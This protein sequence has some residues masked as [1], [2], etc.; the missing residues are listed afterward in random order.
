MAILKKHFLVFDLILLITAA[1]YPLAVFCHDGFSE[2]RKIESFLS[3]T[4]FAESRNLLLKNPASSA[5]IPE[6]ELKKLVASDGAPA[7]AFGTSVDIDGD[8]MVIGSPSADITPGVSQ[9]AAYIFV[10]SGTDW[11]FQ[12]KL[13]AF[14]GTI[15]ELFGVSVAISGNTAIVGAS[16]ADVGNNSDQGVVY[17]FTR[18]GNTWSLE[19][20]IIAADGAGGSQLG[21]SVALDGDTAVVGAFGERF[22][23]PSRG[24]AYIF[25][26]TSGVWT[27]EAK[28]F[29]NVGTNGT[30][31]GY[32]VSID[33]D[34]A[35]VGAI[36]A[37][38]TP[39]LFSGIA[40]VYQR[41]AGVWTQQARLFDASGNDDDQFGSGVAVDAD[42]IIV[43]APAARTDSGLRTGAL[44][45]YGRNGNDWLLR[46]KFPGNDTLSTDKF[47]TRV[48]LSGD[49]AIV[50]APLRSLGS[51]TLEGASYVFVRNGESWSQQAKLLASDAF[52][53]DRFGNS[54]AVDGTKFLVGATGADIGSNSAQGAAYFFI[55]PTFAPDLQAGSDSGISNSDN[56]TMFQTLA[57]DIGGVTNGASIELLRNGGVVSSAAAIGNSIT[58]TDAGTPAN[59]TFQYTARQI[60]NG[61]VS[62]ESEIT[63]VRVDNTAPSVTINQRAG[64][65]DPT[66]TANVGFSVVFSEPVTGFDAADVSLAGSTANVSGATVSVT[67]SGAEYIVTISNFSADNLTVTAAVTSNAANDAA[68]NL[69]TASTSTDNT[70][71]VDNVRPKV[72][73]NQTAAQA[74]PTNGLPLNFTVVFSEPITGFTGSDISFSG[75]TANTNNASITISGS[76]LTYNVAVGNIFSN[77]QTIRASVFSGGVQDSVG[78]GNEPSTSTDNTITLDNVQP[79]VTINQATSQIDPTAVLPVNF[80]VFFSEPVTGFDAADI[81]FAG[82]TVNTG[83]ATVNI[84][85]SGAFYNVAVGNIVSN[86]G[87]VQ[88]SILGGAA[89]DALGNLSLFSS[90]TDNRVTIDNIAPTVTINQAS[91]QSDPT[92]TQPVAFTVAFSE[93]VTGFSSADVSLTGSTANVSVA[94]I[95]VSGSGS[96]YTVTVRNITSAGQVKAAIPAGAA[97]DIGGNT[98]SASTST[99]NTI[100]VS[101]TRPPFDFDGDNKTDIGIFRPSVGEWWLNRSSSGQTVAAQF[102]LSTDKPVAADFTGDGKTDI[103]FWRP[104][105]GEWFILRSENSSFLSFPFGTSGDVPVV[106]DFDGDG[107]ADVGVFRPSTNEWFISRSSGGTIIIT[108]GA[109]GDVP[110][111]ADYDGDGKT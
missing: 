22:G 61:E 24:A 75:S 6:A 88:V 82:S 36:F 78:N 9:G 43:G 93:P 1:V 46:Q 40:C 70:V 4:Q 55:K 52:P 103:A 53:G 69:S 56:I 42:T 96:L 66:S 80:M 12:A 32:S 7:D 30:Q 99:D 102:G 39:T 92:S 8:T 13:L 45:V 33:N 23:F 72:T 100:T 38:A 14:N 106:G 63:T 111:T 21:N 2:T 101:L 41:S 19:Q 17:V 67:G 83:Q 110:V 79:T 105:S 98:N 97:F 28:V 15:N 89:Q 76:G 49:L 5:L 74:D 77:G 37:D 59:G 48:A 94:V 20:K 16:G 44:Y 29:D 104:S 81:S 62:S 65:F 10:R 31:F 86:G 109:A 50:G 25:K 71:T 85:G 84:T 108:F 64:Q 27:Q 87:F 90:S 54:V 73:I 51:G 11:V 47:G 35:V 3:Q 26:R 57:F 58:L 68:G 60:V 18:T 95:Q 107:K 91:G 34:T